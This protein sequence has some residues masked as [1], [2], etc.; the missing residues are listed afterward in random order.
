MIDRLYDGL[1]ALVAL[2][3]ALVL[4]YGF[5]S[6]WTPA[7]LTALGVA[8]AAAALL[9][10]A[11]SRLGARTKER[12]LYPLFLVA[13]I[14]VLL[15][16]VA[17][18]GWLP[19]MNINVAAPF[20][21][22]Y[23]NREGFAHGLR[24]RHGW[25]SHRAVF[26]PEAERRILLVG[27]SFLEAVHV[28]EADHLDAVLERQLRARSRSAQAMAIGRSGHGPAQYLEL[29][30]YGVA[31][32]APTEVVVFL[33][34]GNDLRAVD[35][36]RELAVKPNHEPEKWIYYRLDGSGRPELD[37]RSIA[38]RQRFNRRLARQHAGPLAN[39]PRTLGSQILL[40]AVVARL[41]APRPEPPDT[42]DEFA[43]LG[44]DRRY[45]ETPLD[46]SARH[47]YELTVGLLELA[48]DEVVAAGGRFGVVTIPIFPPA[49][50]AQ[51]S[52]STTGW[53]AEF[54]DL[55]L[56]LPERVL[57]ALCVER[58]LRFLAMGHRLRQAGSSVGE[59]RQLYH[60]GGSGHFTAAGHA[61]FAAELVP[62]LEAGGPK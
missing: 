47:A 35:L 38:A 56:L 6:G 1:V 16:L 42:D 9:I 7:K 37:P 60:L 28:P 34:L 58:G 52:A 36:E 13:A 23:Q 20:G 61:A 25:F 2:L 21:R 24:N 17:L 29:V 57:G 59:I 5:A 45:F 62:F 31:A 22:V 19:G 50:F 53:S 46:A 51:N 33:F 39:L 14:E 49:F 27:D 55:D 10:A 3:G 44:L 4:V 26:E 48:R 40:P 43:A 54:G 8:L 11:R 30:R 12:L 18:A 32:F 15:Q 41:R